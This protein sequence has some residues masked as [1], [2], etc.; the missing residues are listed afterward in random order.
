M[1]NSEEAHNLIE[2]CLVGHVKNVNQDNAVS[3]LVDY[4]KF[5]CP[6]MDKLY[7]TFCA[8]FCHTQSSFAGSRVPRWSHAT[9][10]IF[11]EDDL[12]NNSLHYCNVTT[13][14]KQFSAQNLASACW[15]FAAAQLFV[16]QQ[17]LCKIWLWV[18][19]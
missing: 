6:F 14:H 4:I 11:S 10:S 13:V 12:Y 2:F 1:A 5:L 15:A 17:Q 19:N 9:P 8:V 3:P 16:A 7:D 18:F